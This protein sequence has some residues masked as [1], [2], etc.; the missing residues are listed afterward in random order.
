MIATTKCKIG[1][2]CGNGRVKLGLCPRHSYRFKKYGNTDKPSQK[3]VNATHQKTGTKEYNSWKGAKERCL[4]KSNKAYQKYGGRGIKI[5]DRWSK[6]FLDFLKDMGNAPS[7]NHSLDRR[8]N[9]GNYCPEN[10]RWAT[11]K[12]QAN[13]TR[14]NRVIVF[15]GVKKNLI[16]WSEI[17]G[18]KYVTLKHRLNRG[19]SIEKALG[20]INGKFVITDDSNN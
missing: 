10:C 2:D 12:Q 5:C 1:K 6:S 17:T 19:W 7:K 3:G 20:I 15:K 8:N 11:K 13:N 4:N 14:W 9:N 16:Q 18:I